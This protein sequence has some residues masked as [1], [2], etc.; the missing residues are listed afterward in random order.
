[1]IKFTIQDFNT[2]YPDEDACI[3][4]VFR[5]RFSGLKACK[6][7]KNSFKYYKVSNRKCYA[8]QYCGNQIH[9]LANTIFHKSETSLKN[10][11]YAIFLFSTSKNGVFAMELQRQLGCTYKTAWRMAK[12][13]RK[14]FDYQ[15]PLNLMKHM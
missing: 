8:C 4:E 12:Q 5:Q 10:W 9:P 7:C 11:F 14:L 2:K 6:T 1:M 3:D 13:I 15:K